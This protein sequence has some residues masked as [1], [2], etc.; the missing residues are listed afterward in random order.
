MNITAGPSAFL[1]HLVR[2][3]RRILYHLINIFNFHLPII[4]T[5]AKA[6]LRNGLFHRVVNNIWYNLTILTYS[7]EQIFFIQN[8]ALRSKHL[9]K[10]DRNPLGS[11]GL[12]WRMFTQQ[13]LARPWEC[14]GR[15]HGRV[16]QPIGASLR[17]CAYGVLHSGRFSFRTNSIS[18]TLRN[19]R[20]L[21][22]CC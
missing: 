22:I 16:A 19:E 5:R 14:R 8:K 18:S 17:D 13:L 1:R 21:K 2:N 20:H 11:P 10:H 12:T 7:L 9:T 6:S 4:F 3:N 15:H